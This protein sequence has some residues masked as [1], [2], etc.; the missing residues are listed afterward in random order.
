VQ[1]L[2]W[3]FKGDQLTFQGVDLVT[4]QAGKVAIKID[5]T[6]TPKCI[7]FKIE[8]GTRKGEV[9]EGVYEWKGND[10]KVCLYL[11][12]GNRPLDFTTAAGSNRVLFVLKQ[13]N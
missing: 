7:D 1:N 12:K 10:L 13:Q 9:F 2:K 5:T 11:G 8:V 6:S 4:D 3:N